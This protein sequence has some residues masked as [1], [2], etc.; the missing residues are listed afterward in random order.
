MVHG[1][2]S[3]KC[4]N[5]RKKGKKILLLI[6]VDD[7][8]L[9]EWW[10]FRWISWVMRC[11]L[12]SWRD[13]LYWVYITCDHFGNVQDLSWRIFRYLLSTI[14]VFW[15][16]HFH[17]RTKNR[18]RNIININTTSIAN[19]RESL[20]KIWESLIYFYGRISLN[21]SLSSMLPR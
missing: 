11:S 21:R 1:T 10:R 5:L 16:F 4:E 17:I 14:S 3:L 8:Y 13:D 20:L 19:R 7:L 18:T 12:E 6:F 2:Q 15:Y 9:N